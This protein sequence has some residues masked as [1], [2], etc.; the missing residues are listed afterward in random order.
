MPRTFWRCAV[1]PYI[2]FVVVSVYAV[3]CFRLSSVFV[4]K[5]NH[6]LYLS[7][8]ESLQMLQLSPGDV[9]EIEGRRVTDAKVWRADRQDWGRRRYGL[10]VM[11]ARVIKP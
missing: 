3:V 10:T 8:R 1:V 5:S 11:C 4:H 6:N 7:K 2:P 9:I